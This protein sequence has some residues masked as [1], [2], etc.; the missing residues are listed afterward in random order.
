[1]LG[2]ASSDEDETGSDHADDLTPMRMRE[3]TRIN[4][5]VLMRQVLK[6][7]IQTRMTQKIKKIKRKQNARPRVSLKK[8]K[9]ALD[10][11]H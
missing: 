9:N 7:L 10:S 4:P 6:I 5:M 8:W 1:M 11:V 2:D 3:I